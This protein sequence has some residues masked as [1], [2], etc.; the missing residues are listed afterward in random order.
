MSQKGKNSTEE[1][2]QQQQQQ[3]SELNKVE[4]LQTNKFFQHVNPKISPENPENP[5]V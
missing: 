5:L 3:T 2:Q 1:Q 4:V